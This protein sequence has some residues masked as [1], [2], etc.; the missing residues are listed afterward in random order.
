MARTRSKQ[1]PENQELI[2]DKAAHLFAERGFHRASISELAAACEFSKAWLYHYYD[3]KE[4]ILFAVLSRHLSDLNAVGAR[5]LGSGGDPE[6]R[7]RSFVRDAMR[8]YAERLDHHIVLTRDIEFLPET[9]REEIRTQERDLVDR[10][11]DVLAR[12]RPDLMASKGRRK[13]YA[14]MFFGMLNWTYTWYDPEGPV[15]PDEFAD[16]AAEVFLHG[17]LSGADA[18][19]PEHPMR[20]VEMQG[21]G[22]E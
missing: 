12:L 13:P 3:S 6:T 1:Y 18:R 22:G 21:A 5:A 10:F 19:A 14:M 20:P 15:G 4:A 2:L 16:R 8:L 9:F 11:V 7:F 17:F